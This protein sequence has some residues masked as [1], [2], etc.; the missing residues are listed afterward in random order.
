M[1]DAKFNEKVTDLLSKVEER[2]LSFMMT[3]CLAVFEGGDVREDYQTPWVLFQIEE[4]VDSFK[5]VQDLIEERQRHRE[6]MAE[7]E[8][9][10]LELGV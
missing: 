6:F 5:R 3:E 10:N 7:L 2:E 4:M 1:S 9:A 8:N